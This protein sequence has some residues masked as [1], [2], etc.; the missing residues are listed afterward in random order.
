MKNWHVFCGC[1]LLFSIFNCVCFYDKVIDEKF[2]SLEALDFLKNF[3]VDDYKVCQNAQGKFFVE[4][5]SIDI[6][7][8]VIS[9]GESWEAFLVPYIKKYVKPGS[10]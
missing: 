8:N 6:I 2:V 7:K 10:V 5:D 4:K 3:K 1:G 9:K